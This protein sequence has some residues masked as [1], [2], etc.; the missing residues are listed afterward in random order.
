MQT[1]QR[2]DSVGKRQHVAGIRHAIEGQRAK[3][4]RSVE[5]EAGGW[6]AADVGGRRAHTLAAEQD[7]GQQINERTNGTIRNGATSDRVVGGRGS[8]ERTCRAHAMRSAGAAKLKADTEMD[9]PHRHS[10]RTRTNTTDRTNQTQ[11]VA[12]ER[13]DERLTDEPLRSAQIAGG[14]MRGRSTALHCTARQKRCCEC[15]ASSF[16]GNGNGKG[17]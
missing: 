7:V 8:C 13:A 2:P 6:G 4:S 9:E 12:G 14:A 16:E 17:R 1:E 10:A 11:D 5:S 3:L 15:D